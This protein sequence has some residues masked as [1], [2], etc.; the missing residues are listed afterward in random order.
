M[1]R[2][3]RDYTD[4]LPPQNLVTDGAPQPDPI[5]MS[6]NQS[7]LNS[8]WHGIQ[9][10]MMQNPGMSVTEAYEA[11]RFSTQQG[12]VQN[13]SMP[14][15]DPM[16]PPPAV[17]QGT[18]VA[19]PNPTTQPMQIS[20]PADAMAPPPVDVGSRAPTPTP[21]TQQ[22]RTLDAMQTGAAF[23]PYRAQTNE[24]LLRSERNARASTAG[25]TSQ[26]GAVGQG[27]GDQMANMTEAGLQKNRFDTAVNLDIGEQATKERGMAVAMDQ[28]WKALDH[29][30]QYGSDADF[31]AAYKAATGQDIDPMAVSQYRGYARTM[32]EQSIEKN[33]LELEAGQTGNITGYLKAMVMGKQGYDWKTDAAAVKGLGEEYTRRTGKAFSMSN[34][35][36]VAWA[37]SFAT[38]ATVDPITASTNDLNSQ[39]WFQELKMSQPEAAAQLE[40]A[41]GV[42]AAFM[43][44][45]LKAVYKDGKIVAL[46]NPDGSIKWESTPGIV[47]ELDPVLAAKET[48]KTDYAE[49]HPTGPTYDDAVYDAVKESI[50]RAPTVDEYAAK[51]PQVANTVRYKKFSDEYASSNDGE[52]PDRDT[53]N[54]LTSVLGKEPTVDEYSKY[55]KAIDPATAKTVSKQ[56]VASDPILQ[57]IIAEST[58]HT[59]A[60]DSA[61]RKGSS[62]HGYIEIPVPPKG[63]YATVD[64]VIFRRTGDMKEDYLFGRN[65]RT[66]TVEYLDTDGKWVTG[67]LTG[68]WNGVLGF[69][70]IPK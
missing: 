66:Y 52:T 45:G 35:E 69:R 31:V 30:A 56:D 19:A 5:T 3:T 22:Q 20:A 13:I 4:W 15:G 33:K 16:I 54:K 27:L 38:T 58:Q 6:Q 34:P 41:V 55:G 11:E 68:M 7:I 63:E 17:D 39:G 70:L 26:M 61:V 44:A 37:N 65:N 46:K 2:P 8:N 59:Y 60:R 21:P 48:F 62:L 50:G 36:A 47:D 64:G 14:Q 1:T 42:G 12:P 9:M 51:A 10:R 40:D 67:T 29:A 18:R 49:K 32:A 24:A 28:S 43:A 57:K 53:F 25:R 23:D